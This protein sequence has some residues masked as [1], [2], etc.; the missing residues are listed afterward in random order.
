MIRGPD[1]AIPGESTP[2]ILLPCPLL[3]YESCL[4]Y[5]ECQYEYSRTTKIF[6]ILMKW[7][8]CLQ[9]A[10][11]GTFRALAKFVLGACV[12]FG[13]GICAMG[14]GKSQIRLR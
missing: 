11:F 5:S 8:I 9:S 3:S 7:L 1:V 13:Y 4:E 2:E 12:L 14:V 10:I 6:P